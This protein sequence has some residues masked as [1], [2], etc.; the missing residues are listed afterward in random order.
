MAK[1][2]D[3]LDEEI[4]GQRQS[5]VEQ[6]E[7][8]FPESKE[9]REDTPNTLRRSTAHIFPDGQILNIRAGQRAIQGDWAKILSV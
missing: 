5:Q 1:A 7:E 3:L 2:E 9:R 8:E 6:L 4:K